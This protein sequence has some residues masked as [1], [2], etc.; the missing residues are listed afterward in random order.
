ML[1]HA[2]LAGL[3][4]VFVGCAAQTSTA[5]LSSDVLVSVDERASTQDGVNV[6]LPIGTTLTT[7]ANLN[8]RTGPGLG[9][10]VRLVIPAGSDVTT[11]NRTTPDG[12]FYNVTWNG[13]AGWSHGGYLQSAQHSPPPSGGVSGSRDDALSR[14]RSG[15]GFSYWWGHGRWIPG[16]LSSATAGSCS[17]AC[18]NCSHVSNASVLTPSMPTGL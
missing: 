17:G 4:V 14:A 8:L 16:G 2:F 6:A 15:V 5:T 1:R 18:P 10:Q 7:T 13:V 12:S 3:I 9:Y 11:V